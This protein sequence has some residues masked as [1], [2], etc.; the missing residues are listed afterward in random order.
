[1]SAEE[2]L[3]IVVEHAINQLCVMI[4]N[5][6]GGDK[7]EKDDVHRIA[8]SRRRLAVGL[9]RYHLVRQIHNL[10]V[11]CRHI[12]STAKAYASFEFILWYERV[13]TGITSPHYFLDG[14]PSGVHLF[15]GPTNLNLPKESIAKLSRHD[16]IDDRASTVSKF[17]GGV[18]A[19]ITPARRNEL[20]RKHTAGLLEQVPGPARFLVARTR[21][22]LKGLVATKPAKYFTFC[23]NTS[24]ARKFFIGCANEAWT[25]SNVHSTMYGDDDE[26]ETSDAYWELIECVEDQP[27]PDAHRFCC[28]ACADQHAEHL[29]SAMPDSKVKLDADDDAKKTGRARV[30]EAFKLALERNEKAARALRIMRSEKGR[31]KFVVSEEE[32]ECHRQ[33]RITALNVD[34]GLLYAASKLAESAGMSN[35]RILPGQR[36]GWR[37][38]PMLYS[39]ALNSVVKLYTNNKRDGIISSMLTTPKFMEHMCA[40][41]SKLF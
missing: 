12:H 39:K 15:T 33:R 25:N 32:I 29:K 23:A 41:A 18:L 20:C 2:P 24:C 34:I 19:K 14:L 7:S 31:R 11:T 10:P 37:N 6:E 13:R 26:E 9:R 1:M 30:A 17:E 5:C 4:S 3:A 27:I 21:A 16:A 22:I 38:H 8:T 36:Q 28:R 35:G 40:L